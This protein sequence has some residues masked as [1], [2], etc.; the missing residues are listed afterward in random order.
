M[1]EKVLEMFDTMSVQPDEVIGTILFNACAKV[2][3]P[4]A[5]K[6]GKSMLTQPPAAFFDNSILM[7]SATDMLMKFGEVNEAEQLF[8]KIKRKNSI[9]YGAMMQGHTEGIL[10]CHQ[11]SLYLFSL[12]YITNNIPMKALDLYN[13]ASSMLDAN[14]Y[15]I[16]YSACS[17]ASNDRAI[18]LGKQLLN[19]MPKI[20]EDDSILMGS[21]IHMLMK[22]SE[23][24]QAE[25]LFSRMKK[26]APSM[27]GVMMNGYNI[28]GLP[29]KALDLFDR[30][31]SMLNPN[32]YTIMYSTCATLSN[33]RAI[34]LG[35]QLLSSM[36]KMFEADSI[37]M[38]SAIHML[39]KF[40][41]VQQA[42]DLFTSMKKRDASSYGVIMNGYNLNGL[43][44][45][46]LDLFDHVS[47]MLNPNLYTIMYSTCATLSN[48]RAIMLGKQL[49]DE[50]PKILED[51]PIIIGSA[52]HMLMK[53]GE[54]QRAE[55]LFSKMK[56]KD[57]A[58]YAIMM[59]GYH[60]NSEPRKCLKLFEE[61]KRHKLKLDERIYVSLI[62]AYSRIGMISM[63]REFIKQISTEALNSSRV[64]N[65]LIDMWV[66]VLG[67]VDA[68]SSSSTLL[69]NRA[70]QVLSKK[71]SR[72]FNR[73]V[74]LPQ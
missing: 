19:K 53:F 58:S 59:N 65:S 43:P 31:S 45:K 62:G 27:F 73:S 11:M 36:P 25:D 14:L 44:E 66:S 33:E 69:Y 42:E 71:R 72:C 39:M 5:V 37:V 67:A 8:K 21:A 23:V 52:I 30:A 50:M 54:V 26:R 55:H 47:S 9:V 60:I 15:A 22:F 20:F 32:L 40:G 13:E 34:L 68:R 28:N 24:Q 48:E 6:L 70:N 29:E 17:A 74:N 38:G 7:N 56:E 10:S 49:L 61:V 51:D 3:D 64:Q 35:K 1:P 2:A 57:V 4:R 12:G 46:A 18:M 63:C 41:E 16:L